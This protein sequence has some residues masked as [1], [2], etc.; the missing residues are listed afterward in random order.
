VPAKVSKKRVYN[1]ANTTTA[2]LVAIIRTKYLAVCRLAV[3]RGS[4]SGAELNVYDH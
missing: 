2:V 3:N 4:N 1:I